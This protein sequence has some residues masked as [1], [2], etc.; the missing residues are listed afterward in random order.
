LEQKTGAVF[1]G[2][3]VSVGAMVAAVLKKLID[4]VAI[5]GM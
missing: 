5:R 2:T 1:D 3:T 4:Q